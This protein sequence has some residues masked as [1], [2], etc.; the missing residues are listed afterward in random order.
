MGIDELAA[1]TTRNALETLPR[2]ENLMDM[3][4]RPPQPA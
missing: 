1:A 3:S 4:E 2:L